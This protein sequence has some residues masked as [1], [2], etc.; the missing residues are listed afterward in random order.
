MWTRRREWRG[1]ARPVK[2]P[3][4][5]LIRCNEMLSYIDEWLLALDACLQRISADFDVQVLALVLCF[6]ADG[7]VDVLDSLVPLVGQGGLL[8]AFSC[9]RLGVCLL[10]LFGWW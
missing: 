4:E 9:A 8:S 1:E 3:S 6:D 2:H 5:M 10:A 7:D